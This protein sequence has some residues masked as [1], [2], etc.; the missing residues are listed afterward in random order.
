MWGDLASYLARPA[1]SVIKHF[2]T[3]PGPGAEEV[4]LLE[5]TPWRLEMV[6]FVLIAEIQRSAWKIGPL[7]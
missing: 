5:G 6:S 1:L 7:T 4:L 2:F 3:D